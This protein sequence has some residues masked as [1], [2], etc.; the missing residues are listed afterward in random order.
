MQ[1]QS[2]LGS[3]RVIN[4]R[5]EDL[6][7]AA[8][9]AES[10]AA[11]RHA[12]VVRETLDDLAEQ[13]RASV[14]LPAAEGAPTPEDGAFFGLLD[15]LGERAAPTPDR[16]SDRIEGGERTLDR[17]R[18][19]GRVEVRGGRLVVPLGRHPEGRNWWAL[20]EYLHESMA[21]L[22]T[23]ASRVRDRIV[24]DDGAELLV[25]TWDSVVERLGA[26]RDVLDEMTANGRYAGRRV[27]AGDGPT[28]FVAWTA[29]QFRS[30]R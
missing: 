17:L 3:V 24:V 18:S 16:L 28:E 29:D 25:T 27:R 5:L 2:L 30:E 12:T 7:S 6:L 14:P 10:T 9:L 11:W 4:R 22:A 15:A 20:L 8:L 1:A 26:L 21:D 23:R 19:A 13:L